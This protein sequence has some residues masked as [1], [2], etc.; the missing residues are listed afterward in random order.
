MKI[1]RVSHPGLTDHRI[2][3]LLEVATLY[4]ILDSAVQAVIF[5][6]GSFLEQTLFPD[7]RDLLSRVLV[8]C[9]VTLFSIYALTVLGKAK[10]AQQQAELSRAEADRIFNG[11]PQAI[12]VVGKDR[13]VRRVNEAFA[14]LVGVSMGELSARRCSR[15]F[16][17]AMRSATEESFINL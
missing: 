4:W 13:T 14:A 2:W 3:L 9:L 6:E 1:R 5:R 8:V 7:P 16:D 11:L 12:C 17:A 15:V 10:Q